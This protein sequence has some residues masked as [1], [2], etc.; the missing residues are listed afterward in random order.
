MVAVGQHTINNAPLIEGRAEGLGHVGEVFSHNVRVDARHEAVVLD[1]DGRDIGLVEQLSEHDEP[2][3]EEGVAL[4]RRQV[5][6]ACGDG[7]REPRPGQ[8]HC[9]VCSKRRGS[10]FTDEFWRPAATI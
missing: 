8:A 5:R 10:G 7:A 3:L 4:R 2:V 6:R 9:V 1:L